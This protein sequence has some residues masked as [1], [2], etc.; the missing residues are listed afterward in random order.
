RHPI[1]VQP[2]LPGDQVEEAAPGGNDGHS[3]PPLRGAIARGTVGREGPLPIVSRAGGATRT[4]PRLAGPGK[5]SGPRRV[6]EGRARPLVPIPT[7]G[8]GAR[9]RRPSPP[10]SRRGQPVRT[11]RGT[12]G[13]AAPA[14]AVVDPPVEL[15]RL[16]GSG[17]ADRRGL[18]PAE[19][20][21]PGRDG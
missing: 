11:P 17:A 6:Q 18:R 10:R 8:P 20:A 7:R 13:Q 1:Q 16:T 15:L 9:T 4:G 19:R 21:G 2:M 5:A 12:I 3:L 14:T